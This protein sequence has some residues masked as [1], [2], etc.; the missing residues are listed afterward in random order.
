LP[1]SITAQY[2]DVEPKK[3]RINAPRALVFNWNALVLRSLEITL[4]ACPC[5][6][7]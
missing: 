1:E 2:I 5:V 4:V 3:E 6:S 7:H